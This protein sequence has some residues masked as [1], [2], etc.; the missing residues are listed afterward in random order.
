VSR[1]PNIR[2]RSRE[3]QPDSSQTQ[4]RDLPLGE[5]RAADAEMARVLGTTPSRM[6]LDST[7]RSGARLRLPDRLAAAFGKMTGETPR[8][9]RRRT[10]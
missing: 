8:E 9:W 6:A 7:S 5:R 1:K 10:R 2:N 4:Q 3:N